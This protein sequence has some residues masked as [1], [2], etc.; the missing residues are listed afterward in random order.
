MSIQTKQDKLIAVGVVVVSPFVATSSVEF[1]PWW[2]SMPIVLLV[3]IFWF[4]TMI[5]I[6]NYARSKDDE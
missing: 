5:E 1:L 4:G 2:L 6:G 3:L